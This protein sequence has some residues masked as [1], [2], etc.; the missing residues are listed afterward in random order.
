MSS[1]AALKDQS[2]PAVLS[3][4]S[5]VVKR[6]ERGE[7]GGWPPIRAATRQTFR[8]A[9]RDEGAQS[10]SGRLK[11]AKSFESS[12]LHTDLL[13]ESAPYSASSVAEDRSRDPVM[14]TN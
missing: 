13:T 14:T 8:S 6:V 9:C 1:T 12:S 3:N 4:W 2:R 5:N 11:F 7:K 10:F